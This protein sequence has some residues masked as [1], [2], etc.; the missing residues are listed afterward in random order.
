MLQSLELT[1]GQSVIHIIS[2]EIVVI[3]LFSL[4]VIPQKLC[5]TVKWLS[6]SLDARIVLMEFKLLLMY[7]H[8]LLAFDSSLR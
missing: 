8:F 5:H 6:E 1:K 3:G 7:R 2:T 4:P